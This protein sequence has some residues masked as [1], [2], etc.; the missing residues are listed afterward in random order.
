MTIDEGDPDIVQIVKAALSAYEGFSVER[1]DPGQPF[2]TLYDIE[3]GCGLDVTAT[4]ERWLREL[5]TRVELA[6]A[7]D[8]QPYPTAHAYE[9]VCQLRT[10]AEQQLEVTRMDLVA[11]RAT[12]AELLDTIAKAHQR[13]REL[14]EDL[15]HAHRGLD[16]LRSR[17]LP[18]ED[19]RVRAVDDAR[20]LRAM[21]A[22][23]RNKLEQFRS[24]AMKCKSTPVTKSPYDVSGGRA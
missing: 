6:E 2:P 1:L 3:Q 7:H 20:E 9:R 23:C 17:L 16:H 13:E 11:L 19:E 22:G 8:R 15:S 14:R 4:V 18:L 12:G 21:L 5:V 24:E 10:E